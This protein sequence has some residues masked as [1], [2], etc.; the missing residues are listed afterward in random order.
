M[1]RYT[2]TELKL[3]SFIFLLSLSGAQNIEKSKFKATLFETEHMLN[4]KKRSLS[5]LKSPMDEMIKEALE[6][7]EI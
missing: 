1:S 3:T 2:R 4:L 7:S 5:E 6:I